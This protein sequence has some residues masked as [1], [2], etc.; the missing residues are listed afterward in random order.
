MNWIKAAVLALEL[1]AAFV[2]WVET[3]KVRDQ[4]GR[5][6][7]AA[8]KEKL[9]AKVAEA[10]AARDGVRDAVARNPAELRRDDGYKID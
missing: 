1:V 10:Q 6:L 9:N 7:I 4:V 5:D 8:A 2:K 3:E